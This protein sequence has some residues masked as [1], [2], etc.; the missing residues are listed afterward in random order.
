MSVPTQTRSTFDRRLRHATITNLDILRDLARDLQDWVMDRPCLQERFEKQASKVKNEVFGYCRNVETFKRMAN[1]QCL[2]GRMYDKTKWFEQYGSCEG[3]EEWM[4]G[5]FPQAEG[6]RV[7]A[8][9]ER[10]GNWEV[11]SL[12]ALWEEVKRVED[13]FL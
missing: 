4:D 8:C 13:D 2:W 11:A 5:V 10:R 12:E 6:E 9:I 7:T 3:W 1:A